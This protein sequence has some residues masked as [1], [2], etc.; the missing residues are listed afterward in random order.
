MQKRAS[1]QMMCTFKPV[2]GF[3][4]AAFTPIFHNVEDSFTALCLSITAVLQI[5]Q[6]KIHDKQQPWC[7]L[8]VAKRQNLQLKRRNLEQGLPERRKNCLG[9]WT[10][11]FVF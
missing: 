4:P 1:V 9:C 3:Q 6:E 7:V 2:L 10:G 5:G 11:D 8:L